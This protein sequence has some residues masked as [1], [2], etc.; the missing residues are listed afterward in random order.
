MC[1]NGFKNKCLI[2]FSN[3]FS[4]ELVVKTNKNTG[5]IKIYRN[6]KFFL[7]AKEKEQLD[8][9]LDGKIKK[10]WLTNDICGITY[11]DKN[12]KLREI[13]TIEEVFS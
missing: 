8:Y 6:Q 9:E 7:F 13:T 4:N 3:D 5:V 1:N 11:K 10:Q 12:N 2:S